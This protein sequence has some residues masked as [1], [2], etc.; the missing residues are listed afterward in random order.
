MP[1]E[2][3]I[4]WKR[5]V[6][7]FM[8]I[9]A[10]NCSFS[11]QNQDMI[12]LRVVF[13]LHVCENNSFFHLGKSRWGRELEET[14]Q[15]KSSFENNSFNVNQQVLWFRLQLNSNK[16][17]QILGL[18]SLTFVKIH[19]CVRLSEFLFQNILFKTTKYDSEHLR[20][21][22]REINAPGRKIGKGEAS[23]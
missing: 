3:V 17:A 18:R 22:I 2:S 15:G 4:V 8:K 1:Q 6:I 23:W 12:L 11:E 5:I 14:L 7:K 16:K 21:I 9:T 13:S 19:S 10:R 20:L